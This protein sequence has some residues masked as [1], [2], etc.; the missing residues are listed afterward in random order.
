MDLFKAKKN[1]LINNLSVGDLDSRN[2]V[3]RQIYELFF[4]GKVSL[5]KAQQMLKE[6]YA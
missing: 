4:A 5:E 6:L 2:E 3:A 1:S